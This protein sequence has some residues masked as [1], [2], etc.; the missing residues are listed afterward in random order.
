MLT[1]PNH[2]SV[3]MENP[4]LAIQRLLGLLESAIDQQAHMIEE[5]IESPASTSKN[6]S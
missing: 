1:K 5:I 4:T 3:A 2:S 6:R